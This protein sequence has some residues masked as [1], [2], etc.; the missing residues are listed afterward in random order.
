MTTPNSTQL[1]RHDYPSLLRRLYHETGWVKLGTATRVRRFS[2]HPERLHV[3]LTS[4]FPGQ[5]GEQEIVV[6][7][8]DF[9]TLGE[10][11]LQLADHFDAMLS[12][13]KGPAEAEKKPTQHKPHN[14]QSK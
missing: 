10:T 6:P 14:Q 7:P 1:I 13:Q 2:P 12:A 3:V 11:L 4:E 9:R 8:L 5:S